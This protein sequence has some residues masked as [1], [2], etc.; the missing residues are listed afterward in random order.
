PH[1]STT[2]DDFSDP[3]F[4]R[5]TGIDNPRSLD[6]RRENPGSRS[7]NGSFNHR[8]SQRMLR[9]PHQN[10]TRRGTLASPGRESHSGLA[11]R[12]LTT[13]H[14]Q[15]HTAFSCHSE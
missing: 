3:P 11:A 2:R 4:G 7:S 8:T 12:E 5:V 10:R 13:H 1:S 15:A 9:L 6:W 14:A